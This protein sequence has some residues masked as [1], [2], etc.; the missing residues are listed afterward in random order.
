MSRRRRGATIVMVSILLVAFLGV[1]AIAA[2]IGRFYTVSTELQTAADAGALAGALRLQRTTDNPE[3]P[4]VDTVVVN[5]VQSTNLADGAALAITTNDVRTAIYTPPHIPSSKPLDFDVVA[6]RANAVQVTVRAAPRGVFSQLIGRAT[7]LQLSRTSIAWIG[8]L[9]GK[10]VLP[11]A[12][13][14]SKLYEAVSQTTGAPDPAPDLEPRDLVRFLQKDSTQRR[15]VVL[16]P[17]VPPTPPFD[18]NWTGFNLF[19]IAGQGAFVNAMVGCA[20]PV[21]D[22]TSTIGN[23]LPGQAGSYVTWTSNDIIAPGLGFCFRQPGDAGCYPSQGAPATGVVESIAWSDNP[24][25]SAV[26]FRYVGDFIINCYFTSPTEVCGA[27]ARKPGYAA[28]YPAGTIIGTMAGIKSRNLRSID[29]LGI[30][31]SNMQRVILVR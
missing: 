15:F 18:G 30:T 8:N 16:G 7:N 31:P 9:G 3:E 13:P 29:L 5:F 11:W 10:C 19:G 4:D 1:G 2:D 27:G 28:S 23:A 25:G 20:A 12:F 14:Y 24:T 26:R 17:L 22:V 6:R 21:L